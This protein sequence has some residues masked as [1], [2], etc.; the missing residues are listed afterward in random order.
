MIRS[1]ASTVEEGKT[2]GSIRPDIDSE[3]VAWALHA[4]WWAEDIAYVMGLSQFV[5]AGRST[6]RGTTPSP[7]G[8]AVGTTVI[9]DPSAGMCG[10]DCGGKL[11]PHEQ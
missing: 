5:T 10:G 4:V 1:V 9:I 2:Q 7:S 8:R 3:Q 11:Y 6:T